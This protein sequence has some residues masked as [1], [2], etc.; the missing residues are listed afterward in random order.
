AALERLKIQEEAEKIEAL[1]AE[2]NHI[3]ATP[4]RQREIVSE[5]LDEIVDRYG[6]ERRTKI[7]A[8]FDGDVS[9]EDLIPE[10]EVVVTIT[11]GGYAKRTQTNLYRAQHRGGKGIKGAALRGDDVVEQFFVTSTHNWLLFF[12]NTGRVYRAKAYELPEGTRDAKGQH[13]ANLLALQPGE[14]IAKVL[15]IRD[16]E[17]AEFLILATRSGVVKKTRLSEYDSNRTGGVIAINLREYKGQPDELVSARIVGS[18]DHLLMISRKGMS[19]R[20]AADDESIRPLGRVTGGV[21]GMKFKGDDELL[22]MDVVQ[23]D[24]YVF[25]VTEAGYAKRTP[26]DEYRLQ[27]RGGLGI[28]VAKITEQRGD[29]VGGLIVEDGEEVLVVMEK[30]KIV[31]ASIDEVPAKGRNTMG[32]VFAKP[33][34]KDRIIAVTR[35]PEAAVEDDD[36]AEV[37]EGEVE[38][39]QTGSEEAEER[40]I[41]RSQ[42]QGR[43]YARRA[44]RPVCRRDRRRTDR[45][46]RS[47]PAR[48][49]S[50]GPRD[51]ARPSSRPPAPRLPPRRPRRSPAAHLPPVPRDRARVPRDRV[52]A[53]MARVPR[54]RAAAGP[55]AV[56]ARPPR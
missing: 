5:E 40:A 52:P 13:V 33:D 22:T 35:G 9:M 31:R 36:D 2:Y 12:T 43:S 11:R 3:L 50:R 19:I 45:S 51:P 37:P 23:P 34:K 28:R 1:I 21:T 7:L 24:T 15:S 17:E 41:A 54:D 56:I 14:S 30:G 8:G 38:A 48:A 20:F 42:A 29:L 10:E 47:R 44:A 16:Y 55:P 49:R 27:G 39:P 6:D 46:R 53:S 4:S 26:V 25:V 32:V 18:D